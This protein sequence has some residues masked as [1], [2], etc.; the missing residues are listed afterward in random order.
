MLSAQLTPLLLFALVGFCLLLSFY[1][2]LGNRKLKRRVAALE[3]QLAAEVSAEEA[4]AANFSASLD[5]VERQQL[6]SN[7]PAAP[8][9]S[10]DK[11]SYVGALAEQGLD[12]KGI[13]EALQMPVAEVE[14]LMQ[15]AKLKR[16]ALPK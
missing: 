14:Q 12:A 5:A 2:L 3:Q 4:P 10:T 7:Q 11:Y 15:L 1:Q 9:K 6:Q 8:V 16:A 13:S